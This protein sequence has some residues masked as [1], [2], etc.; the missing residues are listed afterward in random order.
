MKFPLFVTLRN[1]KLKYLPKDIISGIIVAAMTI[2]IS[3]GYAQVCGMPAVYGL[4]GSVFPILIFAMFST[5]PQFIFGVDAAPCAVVGAFLSTHGIA[6]ASQQAMEIVPLITLFAGLWLLLFSILK[7]GKL[8]NFISTPVMGGFISGIAV[9]IIL[10]QIP[11]LL[12]STS[13]NGELFE[14]AYCIYKAATNNP[15]WISFVVG[16]LAVA[17]IL[18]SKKF[19]PKFPM[20]VAVMIA[21][22]IS[23][24]VFHVDQYGIKLLDSV[25]SGMPPF[26]V[27]HIAL[28]NIGEILGTSL[29]V[30]LIVLAQTLL[31]ENNFAQKNG[32]KINDNREV[33]TFSLALLTSAFTGGVPV[34]GSVSRTGVVQQYGGK[35]Q[36]VSLV[37]GLSIIL[38]LLFG[39]DFIAYLPVPVLTGIVMSALIG[40]IQFDVAKRLIK[41][42]H[43][44]AAIFFA[45][46]FG[47]LL[48]GTIYGVLI[49]MILSFVVVIIRVVNP[50]RAFLGIIP[51]KD[52]FF[53]LNRN[54]DAQPIKDT[55]IYRFNGNL[56]FANV[57]VFQSDIEQSINEHTKAII[58]DAGGITHIDITAADRLVI[59]SNN[60]K[61]K[62]IDFYI[63]EHIGQVNDL[64][65]KYGAG[66]LIDEGH[67]RRTITL[68]LKNSDILPPYQLERVNESQ[69]KFRSET[70]VKDDS[71]HEYEWAYG[72][73]AEKM[74]NKAVDNVISGF[75]NDGHID[76]SAETISEN[77]SIHF[78]ENTIIEDEIL[79]HIEHHPD[80]LSKYTDEDEDEI[81]R[82]I[83]KRR[84]KIKQHILKNYPKSTIEVLAKHRG[85]IA[86][87]LKAKDPE[88]YKRITDVRSK[89]E[90]EQNT[91]KDE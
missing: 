90:R 71:L 6:A 44:D 58:V 11:K 56:F 75:I 77:A 12:G 9:T 29:T 89:I 21:S 82:R 53:D 24:A 73:D 83:E 39:T 7:A 31:A 88:L 87:H 66:S 41:S 14:L 65:R 30:A 81:I 55:V 33:L 36:V 2:P 68:A 32:Y 20:I 15:S 10:M 27:P 16:I 63:T 51:D 46:F 76:L 40:I 60:L 67:I 79:A 22:A 42:S 3:M 19:I 35:S 13:G 69:K 26:S 34:N 57:S 48:L 37:S 85:D 78:D 17:L 38:L 28:T 80:R 47:V 50:S 61:S 84:L 64:L 86:E 54:K 43:I 52:G 72:D 62:G 74:M 23:T 8:V 45:A 5:S 70:L 49:G 1:Y 59:I 18:I 25:D 4:Y 91:K